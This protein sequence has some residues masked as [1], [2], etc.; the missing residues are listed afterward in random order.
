[1]LLNLL[2]DRLLEFWVAKYFC[3]LKN[4]ILQLIPSGNNK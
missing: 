1:M 4:Y 2:V 3:E